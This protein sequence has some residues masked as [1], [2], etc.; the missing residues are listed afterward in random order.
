MCAD[1]FQTHTT[2]YSTAIHSN[3]AIALEKNEALLSGKK[4]VEKGKVDEIIF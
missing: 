2:L 1:L 3:I 4:L